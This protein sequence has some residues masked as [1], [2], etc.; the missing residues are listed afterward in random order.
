MCGRYSFSVA[1]VK[2]ISERFDLSNRL[3]D[4]A[5]R[6][7]IA[8]GQM[9]PVV[10]SHSPNVIEPMFWGLIPHWAKAQDEGKK[11]RTV[12]ARVEGIDKKPTYRDPFRFHR[13]LVPASGF[14]EW[15]K[16]TK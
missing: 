15:N 12:N 2:E 10:V 8:P 4:F 11:F 5:P 1:D 3:F 14:Y 16:S 13:C 7:N 6:Y 9:N